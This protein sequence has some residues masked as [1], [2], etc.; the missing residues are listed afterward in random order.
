MN[1]NE[2]V[3]DHLTATGRLVMGSL[4]QLRSQIGANAHREVLLAIERGAM[5][6][7]ITTV[8]LAGARHIA[9]NLIGGDGTVVN[10][11]QVEVDVD[12]GGSIQ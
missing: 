2:I 12:E 10:L 5:M 6:Q 7:V 8:S 9:I 1:S 4:D 11:G 3:F